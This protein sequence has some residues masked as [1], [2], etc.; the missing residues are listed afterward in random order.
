MSP[1]DKTGDLPS[2]YREEET[3]DAQY[4]LTDILTGIVFVAADR[5]QAD[6][7]KHIGDRISLSQ[8][9]TN[10]VATSSPD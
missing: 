6:V 2:I 5:L 3:H 4:D 10:K 8:S 7:A 1:Q 9:G